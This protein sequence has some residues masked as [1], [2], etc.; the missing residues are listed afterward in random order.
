MTLPLATTT[1]PA[2][3]RARCGAH[4]RNRTDDL[5]LTMEMLYRL[6]YVGFDDQGRPGGQHCTAAVAAFYVLHRAVMNRLSVLGSEDA[7]PRGDFPLDYESRRGHVRAA[8]FRMPPCEV[9]TRKCRNRVAYV[10]FL[11]SIGTRPGSAS[12]RVWSGRR[13]S[14]P[15]HPAWKARALPLSYSRSRHCRTLRWVVEGGGFEPPKASPTD[16]QSVPFDRSGT[17]PSVRN[18]AAG[19]AQPAAEHEQ[20]GEGTRTPNH[21]ITNEMLYQLSYASRP[22]AHSES[23]GKIVIDPR[24]VKARGVPRPRKPPRDHRA[25]R[26]RRSLGQVPCERN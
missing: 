2:R 16:L 21:L 8:Q 4:D 10:D 11:G 13:D 12:G 7:L 14:N 17:P 9:S 22:R 6:S 23:T 25:P 19:R 18:A 20:A 3:M 26:R 15:R 5:L 24:G 1:A